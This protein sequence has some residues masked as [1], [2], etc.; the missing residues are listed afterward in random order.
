MN[1]QE[2]FKNKNIS[3]IKLICFFLIA[4]APEFEETTPY[5]VPYEEE[6][7]VEF[8]SLQYLN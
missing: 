4:T 7:A 1:L 5:Y 3:Q 2:T 8:T 6:D